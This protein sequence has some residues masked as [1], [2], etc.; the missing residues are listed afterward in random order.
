[1]NFEEFV[2]EYTSN[3]VFHATCETIKGRLHGG[4]Y[5]NILWTAFYPAIAQSYIPKA[6]SYVSSFKREIE[7]KIKMGYGNKLIA[8]QGIMK[9]LLQY[10]DYLKYYEIKYD[11]YNRIRSFSIDPKHKNLLNINSIY[12]KLKSMGYMIDDYEHTLLHDGLIV[13]KDFRLKGKLYLINNTADLNIFNYAQ[14]SEI[15]MGNLD[16][17][18]FELLSSI[19]KQGYDGIIINDMLQSDIWGNVGHN[20]LGFYNRAWDKLNYTFIEA[21]NYDEN[22]ENTINRWKYTPEWIEYCKKKYEEI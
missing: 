4:G 22:P 11:E 3:F 19:E 14:N 10:F 7:Y 1:M 15:N 21:T 8:P 6:G 18:N 13:P 12:E 20:S 17:N 9:N 5:D 16:Y 2:E